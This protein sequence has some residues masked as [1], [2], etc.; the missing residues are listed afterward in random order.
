M[1]AR[2]GRAGT[3][4]FPGFT[5]SK[6]MK[7]KVLM[8]D[9]GGEETRRDFRGSDWDHMNYLNT[10]NFTLVNLK[11]SSYFDPL[12]FYGTTGIRS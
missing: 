10:D 9:T 3:M 4:G 6:P 5:I 12:C 8:M 1:K 11:L 2:S 7:W